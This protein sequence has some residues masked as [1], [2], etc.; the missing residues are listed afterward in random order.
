[1]PKKH[2]V[3]FATDG[4]EASMR[5]LEAS[6]RKYGID[7]THLFTEEFLKGVKAAH[8]QLFAERAHGNF[9]WK[10]QVIR[11]VLEA[12]EPG[13]WVVYCDATYEF[14]G[15]I[16]SLLDRDADVLLFRITDKQYQ[17]SEWTAPGCLDAMEATAGEREAQQLAAGIVMVR[18]SSGGR[19]FVHEWERWCKTPECILGRGFAQHRHDQSVLTV[20]SKR[21]SCDVVPDI[22]QHGPGPCIVRAHRIPKPRVLVITATTGKPCLQ[23]A[24]ASVARQTYPHVTH[25]VVC[26]DCEVELEGVL[27][28]RLPWN[29]GADGWNG[30]LAFATMPLLYRKHEYVAFLDD[31]CWFD[32]DHIE[33]ML[34]AAQGGPA[35]FCL[36]AVHDAE[37]R[38]VCDDDCE[39]LG[40]LTRNVLNDQFVDTNCWLIS[41]ELA[42]KCY[43]AWQR[44]F[45]TETGAADEADRRVSRLIF[46]S[47]LGMC[48]M[49]R[50]VHY[51]ASG[52]NSVATE[53][54]EK[55]NVAL[56]YRLQPGK[57]CL[58]VYHF[59]A[60]ATAAMFR[61]R[62]DGR[63]HELDEW[64]PTQLWDLGKHVNLL[65]GYTTDRLPQGAAVLVNLCHPQAAPLA[66]LASRPDLHRM[67]YTL[68]SPNIRHAAQWDPGFL[69]AHFDVWLTYW[70]PFLRKYPERCVYT[71]HQTHWF[72][73][74]RL[75]SNSGEGRSVCCVLE[76]REGLRRYEIDGVPMRQLDGLRYGFAKDLEIDLY[77]LGWGR[78]PLGAGAKVI[79][80]KPKGTDVEHAV[81][82]YRRYTFALIVE[83][84]DAEGYLSEK[85]GDALMAGCIP[86]LYANATPKYLEG[87]Y[88]DL[89]S[90]KSSKALGE[91]LQKLTGAEVE[92]MRRRIAETRQ[93]VHE[94]TGQQA[95]TRSCLEGMRRGK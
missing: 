27:K 77:G 25:L 42:R 68:E 40:N 67:V 47:G 23:R 17:N 65:N 93:A 66:L 63:A 1:M 53:F 26:N 28:V 2:L 8:P 16:D 90:F 76:D 21:Y 38:Y 64:Q 84:C 41:S 80:Q 4:Y 69:R 36:R 45:R 49:Q 22:T 61:G 9:C 34:A 50:T 11:E 58:Y 3:S 37:G 71:P 43:E 59:S 81:D 57:P 44:P 83:N 39:S 20:L 10:P 7:E 52:G 19:Q 46:S 32:E 24:A 85:C 75:L 35:V 14:Q 87:I 54:F 94:A 33:R 89:R 29:S 31:D 30:H 74:P 92:G 95:F 13:S 72:D 56:G 91:Y 6:A 86:L 60:E 51:P 55:G 15:A 5:D 73:E 82:I 70:A 48:A 62:F 88:V 78:A 79:R 18:S 12:V